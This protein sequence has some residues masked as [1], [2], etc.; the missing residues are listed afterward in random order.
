MW[1]VPKMT[2]VKGENLGFGQFPGGSPNTDGVVMGAQYF[3]SSD[4]GTGF[5]L[6]AP[7]DKGRTTTHEVG[8]YLNLRHIWGDGPCGF[9][10]L[11]A[12]TPASNGPSGGCSTQK[13]SCNSKDMVENYMDYSDDA[14][15]SLFTRGQKERMRAVLENGGPRSGLAYTAPKEITYCSSKGNISTSEWIDHVALGGMSNKTGSD[16][17]YKNFS[18]KTATLAQKSSNVMT[19][20]A[21]FKKTVYKEYWN[22]WIDFNQNGTFDNSEKVISGPST[23]N[24]DLWATVKVPSNAKLGKTRM[25]VSM[26]YN[27]SQNACEIFSFGE[28]EDYTVNIISNTARNKYYQNRSKEP[29]NITLYPNPATDYIQVDLT[30][31]SDKATYQITTMQGLCLKTHE[32]SSSKIDISNLRSGTYIITINNGKQLYQKKFVKE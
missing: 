16:G 32:L 21:G 27:E 6:S 22:V 25:R 9:D 11:V 28:V 24:K 14:C 18:K 23:S 29:T 5:Y 3:G 1:V 19:I 20:S 30:S 26:K 8:H 15:M 12:D 13:T 17:G 31:I 7:Y 4:K 10:D 2:T